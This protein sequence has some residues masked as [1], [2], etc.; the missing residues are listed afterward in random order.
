MS[1]MRV[2]SFARALR[3]SLSDSSARR[4]VWRS[5]SPASAVPYVR[6]W[7]WSS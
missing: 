1:V 2:R 7:N 4:R 5:G 3:A 6:A